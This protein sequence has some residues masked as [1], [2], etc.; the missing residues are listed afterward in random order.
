MKNAVLSFGLVVLA[1]LLA[2]CDKKSTTTENQTV[3]LL[4]VDKTGTLQGAIFDATTGARIGGSD[5]NLYLI[6]GTQNRNPNKLISDVNNNLVGEYAFTDIPVTFTDTNNEYNANPNTTYKVVAIKAGYQRFEAEFSFRGFAENSGE[7]EKVYNIIGNIYLFPLGVSSGDIEIYVYDP[8]GTAIPNTIVY[9]HQHIND[10]EAFGDT[11][12]N[13]LYAT[14]GLVRSLNATTDS[15]GK[16][17]FAGTSLTLGGE[18]QGFVPGL[19][20]QGQKLAAEY[21]STIFVGSDVQ[22][23]AVYLESAD[24]IDPLFVTSASNQV[25]GTITPLGVLTIT[26]NQPIILEAAGSWNA[27]FTEESGALGTP[28]VTAV[29]SADGLTLTITPLITTAPTVK[30][31]FIQYSFSG[32]V[33]LKNSQLDYTSYYKDDLFDITNITTGDTISNMVQ[34]LSY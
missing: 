18:Y 12:D 21:S 7:Y 11:S 17:T 29:L 22:T 2:A 15:A 3:A 10:N 30:G 13:T 20:F 28:P 5:L 19:V 34:I 16:A 32:N 1:V 24:R 14:G 27:F 33:Y 25:P 31:T 23:D 4:E 9:L 8:E 6:Q 26:F